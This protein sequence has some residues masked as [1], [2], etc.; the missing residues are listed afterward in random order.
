LIEQSVK[1]LATLP[2][3]TRRWLKSAK[4]A[5][6]NVQPLA[7]LQNPESQATYAGYTI[8]FV[9]FYLR[10]IADE[11]SR[12]DE[13]L[14]QQSRVVDSSDEASSD[15]A[16]TESEYINSDKD[17]TDDDSIAPPRTPRKTTQVDK[18][19]DVRE[20]FKWKDDQKALAMQLWLTLDNDDQASQRSALLDSLASFILT[21]YGHDELSSGLMQYLAVLGIDTQTNRLRTVKNYS[22]MLAGVVYCTRVLA[23]EKLLPAAQ[24]DEQTEAECDQFLESRKKYLADGS[25]SPMSAMLGL[26]AYGKYAAMREGNA[27]N[28]SWSPDKKTLYL[29]G[30]PIVIERFRKM[31]QSMEAELVERFWPLCFV[32]AMCRNCTA[33]V[34]LG[35]PQGRKVA[36][37]TNVHAYLPPGAKRSIIMCSGEMLA[38]RG[39]R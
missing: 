5:E 4:Q 15:D 16:C 17:S 9:C 12:V 35:C 24:R 21:G 20:L 23:V 34:G 14:S 33:K 30:R 7:R 2:R 1:G 26:L 31:A 38:P 10:I 11:E 29:N 22:Y 25:Y 6:A 8:R 13:F 36:S 19:K 18:M 28:A 27:G 3:E 32:N 37:K 39:K